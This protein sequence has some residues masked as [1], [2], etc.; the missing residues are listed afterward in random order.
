MSVLI[1]Q[2]ERVKKETERIASQEDCE[3][4]EFKI[5]N[6]QGRFI[7]RAL[8]DRPSGGI[9]IGE[10]SKINKKVF[11]F[12]EESNILGEDFTVEINSPGLTRLLKSSRDF[13][14]IK[15]RDICLWLQ[16]P[17]EGKSYWEGQLLEAD[18]NS[19]SLKTK[20]QILTID[21]NVVKTGKE[22]VNI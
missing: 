19:L 18:E 1:P 2:Q 12:L 8:V 14:R 5:F 16:E 3:L 17:V 7:V 20:E 13:I 4:V 10:C 11:S 15:G 6:S 9:T 21:I 22:K